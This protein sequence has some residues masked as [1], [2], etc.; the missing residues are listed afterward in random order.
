MLSGAKAHIKLHLQGHGATVI[1]R[2]L[3]IAR[4]TLYK[5]LNVA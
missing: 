1:S 3:G 5:I 4:A 2:Q